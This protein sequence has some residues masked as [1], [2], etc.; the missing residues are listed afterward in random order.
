M[1]FQKRF[2]I[3][4]LSHMKSVDFELKICYTNCNYNGGA[5]PVENGMLIPISQKKGKVKLKYD[6]SRS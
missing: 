6:Y 2:K 5:F 3:R 4:H 1:I